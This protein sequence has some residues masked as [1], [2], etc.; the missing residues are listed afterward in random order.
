MKTAET[1]IDGTQKLMKIDET[2]RDLRLIKIW[3]KL[4]KIDER[5]KVMKTAEAQNWGKMPIPKS[6]ENW[7]TQQNLNRQNTKLMKID[8]TTET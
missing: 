6:D 2:N 8:E 7:W 1:E 5:W 3:W 4:T